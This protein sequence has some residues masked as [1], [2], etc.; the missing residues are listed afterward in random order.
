MWHNQID[1]ITQ[2]IASGIGAI[3]RTRPFRLPATLR[4]ICNA[5]VQRH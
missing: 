3:E 2:M 4:S 1:K 5:L